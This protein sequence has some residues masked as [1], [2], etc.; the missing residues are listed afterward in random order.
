MN[1]IES[2]NHALTLIEKASEPDP[3]ET[4]QMCGDSVP[5]KETYFILRP[6]NTQR[7]CLA[8]HDYMQECRE[9][10]GGWND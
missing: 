5:K 7:V 3:I 6:G 10:G 4:C 2:L 8:C 1:S 9:L